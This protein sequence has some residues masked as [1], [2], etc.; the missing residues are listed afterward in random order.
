MLCNSLWNELSLTMESQFLVD[1]RMLA[2]NEGYILFEKNF[3]SPTK[4]MSKTMVPSRSSRYDLPFSQEH[5]DRKGGKYSQSYKGKPKINLTLSNLL[6]GVNPSSRSRVMPSNST[7]QFPY[8]L[9]QPQQPPT[10]SEKV[11]QHTAN[12]IKRHRTGMRKDCEMQQTVNSRKI[13]SHIG[14][15]VPSS[16]WARR[17]HS[18]ILR[19]NGVVEVLQAPQTT[20]LL[21]PHGCRQESTTSTPQK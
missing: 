6:N 1:I 18:A 11:T 13:C 21:L 3:N 10:L 2:W 12:R 14:H 15:G 20:K 16:V 17:T 8:Y 5:D 19:K 9:P 7:C 4:S